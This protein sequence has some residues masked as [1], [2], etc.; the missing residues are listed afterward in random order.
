MG[1]PSKTVRQLRER[2][3]PGFRASLDGTDRP[4]GRLKM[5]EQKGL[6]RGDLQVTARRRALLRGVGKR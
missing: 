5:Q 3:G 4:G 2:R 1:R 6:A